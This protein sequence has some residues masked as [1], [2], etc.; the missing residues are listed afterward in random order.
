VIGEE[1]SNKSLVLNRPQTAWLLTYQE[2]Q[3]RA[4]AGAYLAIVVF[5]KVARNRPTRKKMG[6]KS[7]LRN[8]SSARILH[9]GVS[10]RG[11]GPK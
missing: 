4:F 10:R 8:A 1:L 2:A 11:N 7:H 5:K 3:V 6:G 9:R